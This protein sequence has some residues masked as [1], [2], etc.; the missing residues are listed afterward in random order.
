MTPKDKKI[1]KELMYKYS[2]LL[3]DLGNEK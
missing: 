1:T 3:E 2:E